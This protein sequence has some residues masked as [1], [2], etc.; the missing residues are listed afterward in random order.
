MLVKMQTSDT[1]LRLRNHHLLRGTRER[2][3]M[4]KLIG[5]ARA[6]T[7]QIGLHESLLAPIHNLPDEVLVK[8][9]FFYRGCSYNIRGQ[10]TDVPHHTLTSPGGKHPLL[11]LTSVCAYWRDL[12]LSNPWLW[13]SIHIDLARLDELG[14]HN[15]E[16]VKTRIDTFISR[17]ANSPLDIHV[18]AK[19]QT[20]R[21][22]EGPEILERIFGCTERWKTAELVLGEAITTTAT[23]LRQFWLDGATPPS[24]PNLQHLHFTK[25]FA[26]DVAGLNRSLFMNLPKLKSLVLN[27][28]AAKYFL[29]PFHQ[30][31]ILDI[32]LP[33]ARYF[34]RIAAPIH[35]GDLSLTIY[36]RQY[37]P[38]NVYTIK[39]DRLKLNRSP[40]E[41]PF[42]QLLSVTR[43]VD[44]KHLT[45]SSRTY[46][47][48][49]SSFPMKEFGTSFSQ[50]T[51]CHLTT[52]ELYNAGMS[53]SELLSLLPLMPSLGAFLMSED[54]DYPPPEGRHLIGEAFFHALDTSR[55]MPAFGCN[56]MLP[57]LKKLCLEITTP[58]N[59]E[60]M[61]SMIRSRWWPVSHSGSHA[62]EMQGE[63]A[64]GKGNCASLDWVEFCSL[65]YTFRGDSETIDNFKELQRSGLR[66]YIQDPQG[67]R[68][69]F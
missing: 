24:F 40:T 36:Y 1:I 46:P 41:G 61:L 38:R 47:T 44:I 8:V 52:L 59:E 30:V 32:F 11:I 29:F 68:V 12:A 45:I 34:D 54:M 65:Q 56:P 6:D 22:E 13:S 50:E 15:R 67:V 9:F 5:D 16:V 42:I 58:F 57:S 27:N 18:L 35:F 31:D 64:A 14:Q 49:P 37:L 33:D 21:H 7:T 25:L 60:A 63:Q 4:A 51:L 19:L 2:T 66:L 62:S 10:V 3:G 39:C 20:F 43:F 28:S 55:P 23:S 53:E 17:T 48:I 26:V 69:S